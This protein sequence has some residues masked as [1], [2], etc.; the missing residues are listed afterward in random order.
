MNLKQ[1]EKGRDLICEDSP[2]FPDFAGEVV[3]SCEDTKRNAHH[4]RQMLAAG[5]KDRK[6]MVW[7]ELASIQ[8]RR[9]PMSAFDEWVGQARVVYVHGGRI[10]GILF[11][12]WALLGGN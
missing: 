11:L 4:Y 3:S 6:L 12:L 5:D 9:P 10:G 7:V 1:Y 8:L 2:D